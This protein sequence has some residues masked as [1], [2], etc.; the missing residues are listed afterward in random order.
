[1]LGRV[2]KCLSYREEARCLKVKELYEA[3]KYL[4]DKGDLIS[5]MD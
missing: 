3:Q 2:E 1:V 4:T 5:D